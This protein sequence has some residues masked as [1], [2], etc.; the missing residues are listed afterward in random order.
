MSESKSPVCGDVWLKLQQIIYFH[1]LL[2]C[3]EDD[4]TGRRPPSPEKTF[5]T[6][7]KCSQ[8]SVTAGQ[9]HGGG[10][11]SLSFY[12]QTR[13]VGCRQGAMKCF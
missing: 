8:S 7:V 6:P 12:L 11:P 13:E 5:P 3:Y 1:N 4:K 2:K 10:D 9:C